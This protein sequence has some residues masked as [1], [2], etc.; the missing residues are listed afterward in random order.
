MSKNRSEEV[1][2]A[3]F[4]TVP[5]IYYAHLASKRAVCHEN[6]PM[7]AGHKSNEEQQRRQLIE[8]AER[9]NLEGK[10]MS[11][12]KDEKLRRFTEPESRPLVKMINDNQILWSMWYI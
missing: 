5:A 8:L 2:S 11:A 12:H 10:K 7:S 4:E 3:D 6:K 9:I 1:D